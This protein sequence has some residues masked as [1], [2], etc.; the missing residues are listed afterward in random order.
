MALAPIFL[1][2]GTH[3]VVFFVL[4]GTSGHQF[5]TPGRHFGTRG[6]PSSCLFSTLG[7]GPESFKHFPGKASKKVPKQI[8][9]GSP[10]G[11]ISMIF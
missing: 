2:C 3:V 6:A 11:S 1:E 5:G 8:G 10:A 9:L 4:R 7:R